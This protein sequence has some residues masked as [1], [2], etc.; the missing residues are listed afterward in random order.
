VNLYAKL[1]NAREL[2]SSGQVKIQNFSLS[3]SA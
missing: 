3:L 2:I 1:G